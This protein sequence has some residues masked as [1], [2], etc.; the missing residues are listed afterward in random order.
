MVRFIVPLMDARNSIAMRATIT[1]TT[2]LVRDR[3]VDGPN[4]PAPTHKSRWCFSGF[5][6]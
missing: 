3:E 2:Y 1:E 4:P 6:F 5:P